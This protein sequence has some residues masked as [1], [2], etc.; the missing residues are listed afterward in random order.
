MKF[1]FWWGVLFLTRHLQCSSGVQAKASKKE[2]EGRVLFDDINDD[3]KAHFFVCKFLRSHT[4]YSSY[5]NIYVYKGKLCIKKVLLL[6]KFEHVGEF[7][8]IF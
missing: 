4:E 7:Y 5:L 8:K 6:L 2:T 1:V 3:D